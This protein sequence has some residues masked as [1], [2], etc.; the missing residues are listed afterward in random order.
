MPWREA[1]PELVTIIEMKSWSDLIFVVILFVAAAAGIANTM[2]MSTFERTR[3]FGTL[4]AVGCRPTRMVRMV[5][6]ESVVLGL[7]GVAI[8]SVLGAAIV[9]ITS[10]T[11][12]D[13]SALGGIRAEEVA[14]KGLNISYVIYPKFEFR[15]VLYGVIAVTL[16]SVLASLWPAA[17]AARLQ[18]V[19][20][21][22][23]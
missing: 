11:G 17:F 23:S 6:L 14:F 16:T 15:H 7:V 19:E 18:P 20:A 3:E 8:G 12:I 10:Q 4:L 21:M 2:M 9:L 5:L 13:Y 1:A 22:R